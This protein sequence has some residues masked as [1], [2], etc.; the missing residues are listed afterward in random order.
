[1][2]IVTYALLNKKIKS[3]ESGGISSITIEDGFLVFTLKDGSQFKVA[4]PTS[5]E[6][7]YFYN[8]NFYSDKEHT[9]LINPD[10]EKLYVDI[11]DSIK[12]QIYR[13]NG[14]QYVGT[15]PTVSVA[16]EELRF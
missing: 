2:D 11:S 10:T 3:V 5:I 7:G 9:T 12:M 15:S 1:M 14:T 13:Y 8:S 6:F 4:M 16:N